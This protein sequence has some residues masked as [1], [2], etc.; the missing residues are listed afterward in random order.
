MPV[1]IARGPGHTPAV[2]QPFYISI[3]ISTLL[4]QHTT[5]IILF[6]ILT[7]DKS[8]FFI[9]QF[10]IERV[11]VGDTLAFRFKTAKAP[12]KYI[13]VSEGNIVLKVCLIT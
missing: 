10:Y 1:Y 2:H 12:H 11:V 7:K 8:L 5:F 3:C 9:V 6:I 13:A 4:T